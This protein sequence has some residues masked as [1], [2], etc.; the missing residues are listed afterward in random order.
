MSAP[1]I[2]RC[3]DGHFRRV[4]Y[5]LVAFIADYPEQV[6]LTGIVQ[7]WC[8]R[9][10]RLFH[11]IFV[12]TISIRCTALPNN[13][14]T[15]ALPCTPEHTDKLSAHYSPKVLWVEYGIDDDIIV[16]PFYSDLIFLG[17]IDFQPFT[18]D[19]L[20]AN[21]YEMISPDILHQLIKG[22]FKDHLV[23]WVCDYL[24]QE[25]SE[26]WANAILD[27]INRRYVTLTTQELTWYWP[28]VV[29]NLQ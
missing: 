20:C 28:P 2:R 15:Y 16:C 22:I 24:Y 18:H 8:P 13:L 12:L 1:V 26:S 7:G 9:C 4:I 6:L 27:D 17:L 19:F 14:D 29:S 10:A 3:P 25:H 21:I 11:F 23:S 5:D